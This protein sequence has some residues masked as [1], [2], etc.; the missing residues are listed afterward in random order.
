MT[1]ADRNF[2][3]TTFLKSNECSFKIVYGTNEAQKLD[4]VVRD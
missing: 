2:D 3:K 4:F 1:F